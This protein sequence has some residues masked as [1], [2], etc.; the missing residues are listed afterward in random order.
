MDS[1]P[2]EIISEIVEAANDSSPKLSAYASISKTWQD[3]VERRTFRS[4]EFNMTEIDT[5]GLLFVSTNVCRAR[6]ITRILVRFSDRSDEDF[7]ANVAR[8]VS[9][10]LCILA[11]MAKRASDLP[12]VELYFLV[13]DNSN[14]GSL[15]L[16]LPDDPSSAPQVSSFVFDP[17]ETLCDF[18]RYSSVFKLLP[19]FPMMKKVRLMFADYLRDAPEKRREERQEFGDSFCNFDLASIQALDLFMYHRSPSDEDERPIDLIP[20]E[21]IQFDAFVRI[22]HHM[23]KFSSVKV[24]HLRGPITIGV[25][26]FSHLPNL[27]ALSDFHLSFTACT[28]DG[29][30]F[31]TRDDSLFP[32]KDI[33]SDDEDD[34][35]IHNYS[36]YLSE[37]EDTR[38][39]FRTLPNPETI[40]P[41]LLAASQFVGKSPKLCKF[42][43]C[44]CEFEGGGWTPKW[45]E[46]GME[47]Y[48]ELWFVRQGTPR[49]VAGWPKVIADEKYMKWNRLYWRV[50]KHWRPDDEV[51][52]AWNKA[53]GNDT[54]VFFLNE[55]CWDPMRPGF[56]EYLGDL[57]DE[58]V[59]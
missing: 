13:D 35:S 38:N 1:L 34:V 6:F 44:Y 21:G 26:I 28:A 50:G 36:I 48:F 49:T 18:R 8:S 37:E 30:W 27:P 31:F 16:V 19:M 58:L 20:R 12:P 3:A 54:K 56:L 52:G 2:P 57:E 45:N 7:T 51:V 47:R 10:L 11:D 9:K 32:V 4:L 29:R 15:D 5:F 33:E 42:I 39:Y 46:E 41:F 23:D 40:P 53:T 59:K 24:I 43:L 25:D 14:D 22:F 17:R 55:E